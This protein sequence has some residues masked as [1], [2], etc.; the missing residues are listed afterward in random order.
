MHTHTSTRTST[1]KSTK[2]R[3]GNFYTNIQR[4]DKRTNAQACVRAL[5]HTHTNMHTQ[6]YKDRY[7]QR[8]RVIAEN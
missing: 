7:R 6:L 8:R 1:T 4:F 3:G 5:R 2:R